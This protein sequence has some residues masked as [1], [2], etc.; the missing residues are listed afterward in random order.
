VDWI[1][2]AQDRAQWRTIVS[3]VIKFT[4]HKMR[5]NS[6]LAERLLASQGGLYSLELVKASLYVKIVHSFS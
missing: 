4:F 3:T 2:L 6:R 5:R 1:Y